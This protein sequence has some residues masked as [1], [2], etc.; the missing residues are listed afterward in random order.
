MS[1]RTIARRS[2]AILALRWHAGTGALV[3][4][5]ATLT[6][7]GA[8][9][10][11]LLLS[12]GSVSPTLT[13]ALGQANALHA[14]WG[15]AAIVWPQLQQLA[16]A[17]LLT[18]VR[19]AVWLTL[20]IGAA[21]LLA[22][23]LARAAA[24]GGEVLVARAV[25]APRRDI[26]AATVLEAA[27]L[28]IVALASSAVIALF[29]SGVLRA[30]WPGVA[31]TADVSMAVATSLAIA[32]L[33]MA[34]PLLLTRALTTSRLVDD[35]RRPLTLIVPA[36]QLGAALVVFVGGLTVRSAMQIP[37][38]DTNTE[39]S[40]TMVQAL[41]AKEQSRLER[42][43]QF[44]AFL[45][46]Q[47]AAMPGALV[48]VSANGVHRGFG[49]SANV[50]TDCGKRCAR[51]QPIRGRAETVVHAVVSGDT[52]A[53]S[54]LHVVAGRALGDQDRWDSPL[55]TV[56]SARFAQDLFPGGD[57]VGQ[58]IRI[59]LLDDQWFEI[60][61]VV[62]DLQSSALGAVLLPPYAI[63]VSVLQH[64]VAEIEVATRARVI[65]P[66]VLATIGTATD[67][68][69]SLA[70]RSRIDRRVFVWF[71]NLLIGMGLIA[72]VIAIGGLLVMLS[73]WLESQ[74]R[75]LGVRRAVGAKKLD[76]HRLV[77]GRAALV[78]CG[79]S[80]FG[81]WLGLMAW[82]VL[83]RVVKGAPAYDVQLVAVTAAALAAL[84]LLMAALVTRRF[85]QTPVGALLL[86][87][88]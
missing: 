27:A 6:L 86:D 23:H 68:A 61:G 59:A 18:I 34:G 11:L 81:A 4:L 29:V 54:G 26:L 5:T 45:D 84:T 78:A 60:V 7:V 48:S 66:D 76:L 33:V 8:L 36:M 16:L 12:S 49:T 2:A 46:L 64:P 1:T 58:R 56:I 70:D 53:V 17:Q 82:D 10:A 9:P 22:L 40:T 71:T 52:F 41:H 47:H 43:K 28:A 87:V 51:G 69:T 38:R 14:D 42:A 80:A 44:A 74:K 83:P 67:A 13:M 15:G 62:N 24:R 3:A 50:L 55:T 77:L 32:A 35:D 37:Q 79:G 19:G 65:P 30:T 75:E 31:G 25:G 88:G 21:T 72:A 20:A 85:N 39:Q 73:L 57:A 63:Y